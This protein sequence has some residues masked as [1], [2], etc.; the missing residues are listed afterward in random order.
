MTL[1]GLNDAPLGRLLALAGA[2]AS[3]R[4]SQYLAEQYGLTV[5]GMSVMMTL[6]QYG[7]LTHGEMAQHCFIRPATLTGI[8]DTL[9]KTGYV[10]RQRITGDRRTVRL[11]LT[12]RGTDQVEQIVELVHGGQSLTSV[13]ADPAKAAVIRQFLLE[14]IEQRSPGLSVDQGISRGEIH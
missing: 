11:A 3:R 8:I 10:E 7:E 12:A 2:L 6:N 13:D 1:E 5:A 4:W 9:E 14:V